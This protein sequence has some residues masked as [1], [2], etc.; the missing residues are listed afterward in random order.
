M[1]Q[2]QGQAGQKLDAERERTS[3]QVREEIAHTRAEMGDTVAALAA[4]TDVKRQA[5]RAID[6]AKVTATGGVER[7]KEIASTHRMAVAGVG[8]LAVVILVARRTS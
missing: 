7:L 5:H 1:G 6:N 3:G 4:K 2:D 8:A